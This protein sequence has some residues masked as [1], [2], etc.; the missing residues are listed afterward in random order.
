MIAE[1][2]VKPIAD[3]MPIQE[4]YSDDQFKADNERLR[5]AIEKVIQLKSDGAIDFV[6]QRDFTDL[7]QAYQYSEPSHQYK[8]D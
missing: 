1:Y 2:E 3:T 8:N 6:D 5:K 7:L 4:R